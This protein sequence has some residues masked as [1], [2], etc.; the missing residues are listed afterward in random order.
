LERTKSNTIPVDELLGVDY[1]KEPIVLVLTGAFSPIHRMH[2]NMLHAATNYM[3]S[4]FDHKYQVVGCYI[5]PAHDSYN[6]H[7]LLPCYHRIAIC[8]A[9]V[10]DPDVVNNLSVV[11]MVSSWEAT[12]PSFKLQDE[13][14]KA[15][16]EQVLK[17]YRNPVRV[18]YVCGSDLLLRMSMHRLLY[19]FGVIA[20]ERPGY[21]IINIDESTQEE[22]IRVR[23][24]KQEHLNKNLFIVP[25][26]YDPSI[27]HEEDVS[28]TMIRSIIRHGQW[29]KLTALT[30][31]SVINYIRQNSL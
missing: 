26:G 20:I 2:I 16:E 27:M 19:P 23:E 15:I 11:P 10:Q 4:E 9:A 25:C 22:H 12:Q 3:E 5:S 31:P 1:S 18:M 29:D 28:S 21:P 30:Y 24:L 14:L 13:V 7:Y 8:N 17:H 6:K